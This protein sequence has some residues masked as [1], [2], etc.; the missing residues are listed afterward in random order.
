M[1]V[2]SAPSG[3][4]KSTLIRELKKKISG[5]A[6]SVSVTTRPRRSAEKNGKD[7]HFVSEQ[8]FLKQ[9]KAGR[10][11]EC[12]KVHDHWYGTPKKFIRERLRKGEDILLDIDIC[13]GKQIKK[14]FPHAIL[15]FVLPPSF[16]VLEA[17][18]RRRK[19]D[20]EQTIRRR[21]LA[22]RTE[23]AAA[24]NYDYLI[25][26]Q[27]LTQAVE[28]LKSIIIAERLRMSHLTCR[29]KN[30]TTAKLEQAFKNH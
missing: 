4:G 7:Y 19:L 21:L 22:A 13:G 14:K 5:L 30:F 9:K 15:I 6:Y 17:R 2:L 11:L 18:L 12:A 24:K 28:H 29:H 10:F 25:V 8:Q 3:G 23:L 16:S 26:N 27:K 20:D 1:I